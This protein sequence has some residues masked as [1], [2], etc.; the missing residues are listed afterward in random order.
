MTNG[1]EMLAG[2]SDEHISLLES[3][4]PLLQP[5]N[6]NSA[7]LPTLSSVLVTTPQAV[8]LSDVSKELSFARRT[9]LPVLGLIENMSGYVCPHCGD[10]TPLFGQGGGEEFCRVEE[11]KRDQ[12]QGSGCRFLG[13]VPVDRE[14]V[15][16]MDQARSVATGAPAVQDTANVS[17]DNDGEQQQ[18]VAP[19][20]TFD[21]LQ[22][23]LGTPSAPIFKEITRKVLDSIGTREASSS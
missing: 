13:R 7:R 19:Q 4:A 17:E 16:L 20:R 23:Y 15:L 3:L 1:D 14:F 11:E 22:R 12:G 10:I 9:S 6:L 8:S 5:D 21:L 18:P 2:T